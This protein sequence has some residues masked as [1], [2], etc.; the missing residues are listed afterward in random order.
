[1]LF[2][3]TLLP[4]RTAAQG[5]SATSSPVRASPQARETAAPPR[6]TPTAAEVLRGAYGPYRSNNDLL[7]YHLDVRVDPVA[8]T[9]EGTNLVRFRMLEDGSRIQLD[10]TPTLSLDRVSFHGKEIR[11]TRVEGAFFLDFP[12]T[13]HR[14]EVAEV[15]VAYHGAP[16]AKGRFGGMS[17]E[18]DPAGRPWIF[19][20]CEDDGSSIWWP[21]KDQWQDEPQ[22]GIDLSVAVP[23]A[24]T[25][26]SNG[27]FVSRIKL[28]GKDDGYTQWNWHVSYPINSYDVAL[29]IGTYSH[30]SDTYKNPAYPPLTMDFYALPEDEARARTTFAQANGMLDAFEHYFGEYPFARDGYKLIQ[31]PYAG[32]EHQSA[33]AYGNEFD[34]GYLHRDWTG[35]GISPRFDFIIIHESGHEWFGNAVT[36]KDRSDMW[37]HEGW[38]T[39]LESLFVE[40]H[41]GKPDALRYLSGL[42]PKVHNGSPSAPLSVPS[43]PTS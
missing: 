36:A 4:C 23:D 11:F 24:L 14:G 28:T 37:I 41:Y 2:A 21:S 30:F 16:V 8:K 25:D 19:T 42:K 3:G 32:M 38:D 35:V 40:F 10:L 17:F 22:D 15:T 27:R 1:M 31:V 5:N 29:N 12:S 20:A 39:Y 6:P 9:I 26:V 7:Y 13:L 34:N 43:C 18:Q 33:V